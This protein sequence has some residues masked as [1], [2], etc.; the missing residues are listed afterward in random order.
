[1]IF[2][3]VNAW[4]ETPDLIKMFACCFKEV[5]RTPASPRCSCA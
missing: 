2:H 4:Q 3:V 5:R 1:M